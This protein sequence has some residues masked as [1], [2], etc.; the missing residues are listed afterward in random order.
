LENGDA[1]VEGKVGAAARGSSPEGRAV[2]VSLQP[3]GSS[4]PRGQRLPSPP[5]VRSP[6]RG[7]V[8]GHRFL[9]G[10]AIIGASTSLALGIA[11]P[12][13]KLTKFYFFS[14]E[15]SLISTVASLIQRNQIFL[16]VLVFVFSILL[17]VFK[18][19]YLV[20]LTTMPPEALE[21]QYRRLRALEW[22]GKW[23]MHDVLVLAL[24][25][26]FLKSQGI[27]DATSLSGVY[28]FTA[29]VVFM[30]LAYAWLGVSLAAMRA[31]A[32]RL[33]L[34]IIRPP[35]ALRNFMLALFIL[36]ASICFV[37][38]VVLPSIRFTTVYVWKNEHSIASIIWALY[39]TREYFLCT[40]LMV[41][42]VLFPFL[43]L[44]YLL[45]LCLSPNVSQDFR[46]RSISTMEW[47]GRYSMTDVMVLALMIFY[48]NSSGY[49]EAQVLPGVYCF[50]ASA[51]MT[52]LAY[53]WANSA[54]NAGTP[55]QRAQHSGRIPDDQ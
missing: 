52:M 13:I 30:I 18:I 51:I 23:S 25:I 48:M 29:A 35:S 10:L 4:F 46:E 6:P 32:R 47:L 49:T 39:V 36:V 9:L 5:I 24:M 27:Y 38:G 11:M 20:L 2:D 1:P 34:E 14:T 26:F 8:G 21:R 17:P 15:F 12:S 22:L 50:A 53:G 28:F 37:L 3:A 42:S 43:K 55:A 44:L 16:G 33:E 54:G 45:T 19:L 31:R 40:V 7:L 41:F